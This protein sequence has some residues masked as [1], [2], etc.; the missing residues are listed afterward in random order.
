MQRANKSKQNSSGKLLGI[1]THT[2]SRI[3]PI[4]QTE[5]R[6]TRRMKK[7]QR[8]KK[9]ELQQFIEQVERV[10]VIFKGRDNESIDR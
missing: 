8:R 6:L 1:S 10:N 3:T 9:D 5:N 7:S 4:V 2:G